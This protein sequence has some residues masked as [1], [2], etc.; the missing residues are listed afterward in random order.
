MEPQDI[1]SRIEERVRQGLRGQWYAVAKSVQVRPSRPLGVTALGEKL[2]LWRDDSG[3]LHCLH[4]S[5]P[6]R[7]A[8]LSRGEVM[9]GR[10][11]CRYHGIIV[12]G[13][14]TIVRVPAMPN[15]PLEGR[16]VVRSYPVQ[17]VND[18]VFVYFPSADRPEASPLVLPEELTSP[19]WAS[20]LCS[21]PWHCNYQYIGDNIADP[22]HGCY[23]H[24]D[25]FTLAYGAKQDLMRIDKAD[26][27]FIIRRVAQMGENFDW[28]HVVP[29]NSVFYFRVEVPYPKA[30]GPGGPL[31]ILGCITP[32]DENSS[33]IFFWRCRQV[34]GLERECWRYLFRTFIEERHWEVIEQDRKM[35]E[36]IPSDARKRE[37]LYQ[38]DL[39]VV[40]LRR[41]LMGRAREQI[42]FEDAA[43]QRMVS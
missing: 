12:D 34:S 28:A 6:H 38:H 2:V 22:M 17:E 14:G 3:K 8:P 39:G 18:G 33:R 5:C 37:M 19:N 7:G 20:F 31:R 4:D 13:D 9:E 24:A 29:E 43:G 35:L 23:L 42:E 16:Q 32:V 11:A 26:V 30:G 40:R 15:C 1:E 36:G 25:T 41:F 27:G 21:S 10:I